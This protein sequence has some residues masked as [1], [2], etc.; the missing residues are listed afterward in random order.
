MKAA[1]VLVAI[2]AILM[3]GTAYAGLKSTG[4]GIRIYPSTGGGGLVIADFADTRVSPS[5]NAYIEC[6]YYGGPG[7]TPTMQCYAYDG[8]TSVWCTSS[9][10][11][12]VQLVEH[13]PEASGSVWFRWDANNKCTWFGTDK[14]SVYAPKAP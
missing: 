11:T 10:P 1:P 13:A 5:P 12:I 2:G 3:A 7:T 9:D 14:S 4:S 8:T 6:E